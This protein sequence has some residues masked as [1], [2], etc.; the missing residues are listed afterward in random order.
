MKYVPAFLM[1]IIAVSHAGAQSSNYI[2]GRVVLAETGAGIPNASVFITNTSKG[3]VSNKLGEFELLNVP[4]GTYDLV[5]SCIGYE[6]QVYTYKA[7]Q[8]PL[9]LK[10]ELSAK[11]E[12]LQTVIVEPYEKDGWEKWGKFFTENFIG[13]SDNAKDCKIKNYKALRFRNSKKKNQL[14]VTADEPLIIENRALGYKIQYQLEGFSYGFKDNML[15]YFGYTLFDELNEGAAKKRELKNR[16]KA[17]NGSIMHFMSS[18]YHNHLAEDGFEVKRL[19]KTPNLEKERVK[20][21]FAGQGLSKQSKDSSEYYEHILRQPDMLEEYGKPLLTAD[22]L[23]T[24]A[25]SINKRLYFNDYLYIVY[26]KEKEEPE[27]L[28]HIHE[29]RQPFYQRSVVF[30][31]NGNGVLMDV[32]GNYFMPQDFMSYGYWSW[33][34]KIATMLPLDYRSGE[35]K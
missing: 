10:I 25:D 21:I 5:V 23:L 8:L 19:V 24:K 4:E 3:T 26:K 30:L 20:K 29:N 31:P 32:T 1:L 13:T 15:L 12:E 34:E 17:Y 18:L 7:S 27:Y 11:A 14:T 2:K 16:E 22:S 35:Q 6:T 9:R 28:Q 33:S